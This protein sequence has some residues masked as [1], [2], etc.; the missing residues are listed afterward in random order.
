M[1]LC[2]D[3][4]NSVR[5]HLHA[6]EGYWCSL[7]ISDWFDVLD[8]EKRPVLTEREVIRNLH[9]IVTDANKTERTEVGIPVLLMD[10]CLNRNK[11]HQVARGAIGVLSTENRK[12]WS[13]LRS[14]LSRDRNN[15]SCLEIV[16]RAL[17]IVCLDDTTPGDLAGLCSNYLCGTYGL[18]EGVQVGTCTN[19][20]YDKVS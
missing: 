9:A 17:F 4:A 20:W 13:Q 2:F 14:T 19:R 12:I 7:T 15:A 5:A 10:E 18:E 16:D 1:L 6:T 11:S 8:D 3:V